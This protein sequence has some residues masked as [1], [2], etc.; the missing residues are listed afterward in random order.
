MVVAHFH[1]WPLKE[2]VVST[3]LRSMSHGLSIVPISEPLWLD[4]FDSVA[5][6][7]F[8]VST[9]DR[10]NFDAHESVFWQFFA[11]AALIGLSLFR[12]SYARLRG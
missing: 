3:V 1:R 4:W 11:H 10:L 6:R 8:R 12:Q 5:G 2:Y 9:I 7:Y